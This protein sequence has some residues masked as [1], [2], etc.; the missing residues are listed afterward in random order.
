VICL[1]AANAPSSRSPEH[2]PVPAETKFFLKV[3]DAEVEFI[4]ND[5]GEVTQ[6]IL[7]QGGQDMKGTRK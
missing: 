6:I 1:Q 5:K 4:Q 2:A 3:V 7:H